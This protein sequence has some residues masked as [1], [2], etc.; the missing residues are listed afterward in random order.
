[1]RWLIGLAGI[2]VL[3]WLVF[4][5]KE[6]VASPKFRGASAEESGSS[7]STNAGQQTGDKSGRPMKVSQRPETPGKRIP[8]AAPVPDKPGYVVS[9]FNGRHLYIGA[10]PAGKLIAD[11]YFA[12]EEDFR[13]FR[14][15][16]G[17]SEILSSPVAEN[18]QELRRMNAPEGKPVP[19]KPGFIID[20]YD[21]SEI[22]ITGWTPGSIIMACGSIPGADR[23]IKVPG[24]PPMP[25]QE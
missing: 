14:I 9:P 7:Q 25:G 2:L 21:Q 20:P 23:Y 5:R 11:P 6:D 24:G 4:Q 1:M 10:I 19:G 18:D 17:A 15:P 3:L 13:I 8:I 22:D 16:E 12:V